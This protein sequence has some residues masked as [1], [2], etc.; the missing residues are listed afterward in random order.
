MVFVYMIR[1]VEATRIENKGSR[2]G[3]VI[4]SVENDEPKVKLMKSKIKL[5]YSRDYEKVYIEI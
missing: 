4:A 2:P 1:V 3:L 5:K